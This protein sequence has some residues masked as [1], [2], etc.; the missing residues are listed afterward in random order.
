MKGKV[1]ML[2][3]QEWGFDRFTKADAFFLEKSYVK[4]CRFQKKR[5]LCTVK[6][7]IRLLAK[8]IGIWCNGNTTDS[9]P[10]IP[11]SNPGIPTNKLLIKDKAPLKLK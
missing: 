10:V 2:D 3:K 9:G 5:Y 8:D 6:N 1:V 4:V 7:E 11:G